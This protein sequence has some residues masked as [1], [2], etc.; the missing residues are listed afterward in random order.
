MHS[1]TVDASFRTGI[2]LRAERVLANH[3]LTGLEGS[4][5]WGKVKLVDLGSSA[6]IEQAIVYDQS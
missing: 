5:S 2:N 1:T 3:F 6:V 4:Y